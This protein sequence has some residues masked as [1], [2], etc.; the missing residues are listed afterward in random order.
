[1]GLLIEYFAAPSDTAATRLL[2]R[3]PGDDGIQVPDFDPAIVLT[4]LESALTGVD[5][6]TILDNPRLSDPIAEND[7]STIFTVTDE[8]RDALATATPDQLAEAA[9]AL[10]DLEELGGADPDALAAV[11][12][13]LADLSR[14]AQ[15]ADHHL[16]CWLSQ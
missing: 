13:E 2:D 10:A 12:D 11:L 1:V 15:A 14:T 6:D 7:G 9:E 4:P 8:L 16:Y 3:G 5:E